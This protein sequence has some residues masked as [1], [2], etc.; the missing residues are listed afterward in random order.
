MFEMVKGSL[1]N[2]GVGVALGDSAHVSSSLHLEETLI[3]PSRT[4]RVFDV[5]EVHTI[6]RA[7]SSCQNCMVD[8]LSSGSTVASF[9]DTSFVVFEASNDLE[10]NSHRSSIVETLSQLNLITLSDIESTKT[11]ISNG[12]FRSVNALSILS[13]V[14]I[15]DVRFKASGVFDVLEC[16]RGETSMASVI[17]EVTSA[18]NQLLFREGKVATFSEDVPVGFHGANSGEGPAR[19]TRSLVLDRGDDTEVAPFIA[20]RNTGL[21]FFLDGVFAFGG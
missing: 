7:K 20:A 18:V 4:P 13:S 19:S 14:G 10:R 15:S 3:A 9:V 1:V 21:E 16:M 2:Q 12:N 11:H 6:L 8:V 5:P 17:I